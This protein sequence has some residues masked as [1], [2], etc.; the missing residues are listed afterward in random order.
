MRPAQ[1]VYMY[2]VTD[3][4][5]IRCIVV[6]SV[7]LYIAAFSHG[8]LYSQRDQMGFG[9]MVLAQSGVVTGAAGV[10][11]SQR[12]VDKFSRQALVVAHPFDCQ[13]CLAVGIYRF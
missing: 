13:L 9:P 8:R 10:E 12:R 5:S 6:G 2:E 11:I 7:N 4:C 1:I 3:T